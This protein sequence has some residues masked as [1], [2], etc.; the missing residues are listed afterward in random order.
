MI[1]AAEECPLILKE[2]APIAHFEEFADSTLN[3]ALRMHIGNTTD[4]W[5]ATTDVNTRIDEK[6]QEA[7]IVIAF[8]QQ[9]VHL[10]SGDSDPTPPSGKPGPSADA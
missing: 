4:R 3:L 9:D 6:F 5:P 10:F 1:E 2:P 8:P 7:G